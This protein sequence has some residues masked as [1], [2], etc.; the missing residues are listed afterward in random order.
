MST[1][2][3]IEE[4][5]SQEHRK[6][7]IP[8]IEQLS[9]YL[10]RLDVIRMMI[11]SNYG[12]K[13]MIGYVLSNNI[14]KLQE[15]LLEMERFELAIDIAKKYGLDSSSI[16]KTWAI[17]CLKHLQFADARRKFNRYFDQTARA[18]D[19]QQT[20][21]NIVDILVR[22]NSTNLQPMSI[23]EKCNQILAGK[24]DFLSD[25]TDLVHPSQSTSQ[26]TTPSAILQQRSHLKPRIYQE[27]VYYIKQY[28][29]AD[30][31]L[32]FYVE[33]HYWKEAVEYFI[34]LNREQAAS[35]NTCSHFLNSLF[36][37][38]QTRGSLGAFFAAIRQSDP[39]LA[40]LWSSL[41]AICRHLTKNE[42]FNS[43]YRVQ[44][45]MSDYLRAA[46]T[47]INC[48]FLSQRTA[49]SDAV[50]DDDSTA[51]TDMDS[52]DLLYRRITHLEK[53]RDNCNM[54]LHNVE[55]VKLKPGCLHVEKKDVLKQIRLIEVQIDILKR[56]KLK[57]VK[58]PL[59]S[60]FST[61]DG[62]HQPSSN[63][64]LPPSGL[65]LRAFQSELAVSFTGRSHFPPTLLEH[66]LV[67]KSQIAAL[68]ILYFSDSLEEGFRHSLRIIQVS[69]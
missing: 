69:L 4:Y 59:T 28:G 2:I 46:I 1:C 51:A 39:Q 26:M 27:I 62:D 31:L 20:L 41:I 3:S 25:S 30:D 53:A 42:Y 55:Y 34:G 15:K 52:F 19:D 23:K 10:D 13:E 37:P 61:D 12:T 54:Y 17:I 47:Q 65:V 60:L 38:A 35:A 29:T 56:F 40:I 14:Q 63:R 44:I 66:D 7:R 6:E 67:R 58:Y 50:A 11:N 16:W 45:F 24:Y 64:Y 57:R 8:E 49:S 5:L 68:M 32:H 43:L 48:F 33:H 9:L 21:K 36:I 18:S 22:S